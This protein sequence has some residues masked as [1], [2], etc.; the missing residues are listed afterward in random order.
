MMPSS[1]EKLRIG[2]RSGRAA[3]VLILSVIA[4]FI[5]YTAERALSAAIDSSDFPEALAVKLELLPVTFPVHM[6]AG[7]LALILGPLALILRPR[8]AWHRWVGRIAAADILIAGVTAYPV[9]WVAPVTWGSALGFSAQA[10]T[11]LALLA[12]GIVNIRR[13]RIAAHRACMLMMLA[14]TSGAVFFRIYLALW[15]LYGTSRW[16]ETFYACDSWMAWMLPLGGTALW[17]SRQPGGL[18][19]AFR[20]RPA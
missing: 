1:M 4:L 13:R 9:A 6:V 2:G 10:T 3:S 16:Y 17:L 19:L 7:A 5:L 14:T 18:R 15:A 20:P 11:W 8:R 12:L